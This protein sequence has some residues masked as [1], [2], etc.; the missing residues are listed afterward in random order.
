L[1]RHA[2]AKQWLEKHL[3]AACITDSTGHHYFAD[4]LVEFFE[5]RRQNLPPPAKSP[6][7]EKGTAFQKHVWDCI[8]EIP[9]GETKTY[10]ELAQAI[11]KPGAA[12]A[13]GQ[14]CNANPLALIV[15]CHRVTGSCGL[16]GFAGGTEVK[17]YL[18]ELEQRTMMRKIENRL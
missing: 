13:V 2:T 4:L 8:A 9:Y 17:K 5:G 6:F 12:R 10:G 1:E 7:V 11:G 3:G 16:G 18:L 15:P 14:A